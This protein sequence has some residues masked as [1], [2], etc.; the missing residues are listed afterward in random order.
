MK[1]LVIDVK[2]LSQEDA[3]EAKKSKRGPNVGVPRKKAA[4]GEVR[5]VVSRAQRQKKKYVTTITGLD[6]VPDLKIKDVSKSCGKKFS[7]GA[8]VGDTATGGKEI[9]IQGDVY[10]EVPP[11]LISEFKVSVIIIIIT[12]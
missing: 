6:T 3:E 5:V 8:S 4:A 1:I 9:V 7:S 2:C 12:K 11:L 10:F